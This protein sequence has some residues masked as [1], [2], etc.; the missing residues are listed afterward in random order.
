MTNQLLYGELVE[1]VEKN[2]QWRQVRSFAD[3]YVCWVDEKQLTGSQ[4]DPQVWRQE[5]GRVQGGIFQAGQ[6]FGHV[7]PGGAFLHSEANP[8]DFSLPKSESTLDEHASNYIGAP[9]LWGGKT[10]LGI[11]CSGLMQVI[12]AAHGVWLPRDAYQ[13]AEEGET[14]SFINEAQVGDLAFFDNEEGRI[15]HVGVIVPGNSGL[16]IIHASGETRRDIL[17]H[18]GIFRKDRQTY[19]HKLRIIKRITTK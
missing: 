4:L 18:Q 3:N 12:F 17:D 16:E 13:Q 15:T 9:Y 6:K 14:V 2:K 7:L 19:T 11:D 5:V 10:I 8:Q 1:V